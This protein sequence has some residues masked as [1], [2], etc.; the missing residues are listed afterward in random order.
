MFMRYSAT[1]QTLE[2]INEDLELYE[3]RIEEKVS[4]DNDHTDAT[5]VEAPPRD[6]KGSPRLELGCRELHLI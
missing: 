1:Q 6:I 4:R 2:S 5:C 3:F